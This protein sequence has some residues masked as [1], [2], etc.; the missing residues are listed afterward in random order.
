MSLEPAI[1]LI[2]GLVALD[3][4][5]TVSGVV[6]IVLVV[7]AGDRCRAHRRPASGGH[8]RQ[9]RR[10]RTGLAGLSLPDRLARFGAAIHRRR[11][12]A[13]WSRSCAIWSP[14]A[15][16]FATFRRQHRKRQAHHTT[17]ADDQLVS[18]RYWSASSS[19]PV[20]AFAGTTYLTGLARRRA[21]RSR[22]PAPT[23][24]RPR[25]THVPSA[26]VP[27]LLPTLNSRN[28][29]RT[30]TS[31]PSTPAAISA[32]CTARAISLHQIVAIR[33]SSSDARARGPAHDPAGSR[34]RRHRTAA[35]SRT[36]PR[37]AAP[38]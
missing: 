26:R 32:V 16:V 17:V 1:A 37:R 5:P 36:R 2:V 11:P 12:R 33:R 20:S 25:R 21:R 23:W 14:H 9:P 22:C 18:P 7:V 19:R 13:R 3:Q 30:L 24:R 31:H 35:H 6:G 38:R 4:I 29:R 27:A 10:A 15:Y 28:A 8:R 34:I